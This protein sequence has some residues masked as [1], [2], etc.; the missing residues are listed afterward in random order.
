MH[1]QTR[2]TDF[3]FSLLSPF[4]KKCHTSWATVEHWLS[5]I[6]NWSSDTAGTTESPSTFDGVSGGDGNSNGKDSP[7]S[8]DCAAHAGVAACGLA[9]HF[10]CV[11]ARTGGCVTVSEQVFLWAGGCE[12]LGGS[13]CNS[14]SALSAEVLL[15]FPLFRGMTLSCIEENPWP[16]SAYTCYA[17]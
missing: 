6:N 16:Y 3:L 11:D 12:E 4:S 1:A 17:R 9:G 2:H 13:G 7:D 15:P 8:E 14:S 5:G 10:L